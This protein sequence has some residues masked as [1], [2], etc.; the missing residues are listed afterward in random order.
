MA[1]ENH[2]SWWI[3]VET[4]HNAAAGRNPFTT[5]EHGHEEL[6]YIEKLR[7]GFVVATRG[8]PFQ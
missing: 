4:N 2:I 5:V 8:G 3:D 6:R 7:F 1:V